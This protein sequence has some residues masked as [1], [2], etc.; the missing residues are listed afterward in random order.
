MTAPSAQG[1]EDVTFTA[2]T[3]YNTME[4]QHFTPPL[5]N[6]APGG[7]VYAVVWTEQ[8]PATSPPRWLAEGIQFRSS[9]TGNYS[10][11]LS[12]GVWGAPWCGDPGSGSGA[13]ELKTGVRLADPDPFYPVTAWGYDECDLTAASRAEVRVRAQQVLRVR[14]SVL[15]AREFATRLVQDV[16]T[17]TPVADLTEAV[18]ELE[19]E[20]ADANTVGVIHCS[21]F[22]LPHLVSHVLVT[23]SGA[24]FTTASGH[25]LIVDGG[26]REVLGDAL[27]VATSAPL[28]GW[29]VPVEVREA[30][31]YESNTYAVVAERSSVV[32]YEA[33]VG[34]VTVAEVGS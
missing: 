4:P 27:M 26:Y 24:G 5:V 10:G 23:R 29:R 32:G 16:G 1:L 15:L 7:L 9:V 22:L 6:P 8:D 11:E 25:R 2:T 28:F 21:P 13:G 31:D 3:T 30:I 18:G 20:L 34:A 17:P 33:A 12:T 14:E 19:A